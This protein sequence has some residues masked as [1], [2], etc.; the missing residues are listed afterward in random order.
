[1][2]LTY[3]FEFVPHSWVSGFTHPKSYC[4]IDRESEVHGLPSLMFVYEKSRKTFHLLM[5]VTN[6][7]KKAARSSQLT[8][9]NTMA[10]VQNAL[11]YDI[12]SK[13]KLTSVEGQAEETEG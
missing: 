9:K 4:L 11:R 10:D 7:D 8:L 2:N 13:S 1:M 6:V 3:F 12:V 5:S